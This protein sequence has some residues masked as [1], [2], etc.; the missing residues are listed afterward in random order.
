KQMGLTH[1]GKM[2]EANKLTTKEMQEQWKA[3]PAKDRTMMSGMMKEMSQT[4]DQ[5]SADIKSSG[6]L[7]VDDQTATLTVKKTTKDKNGTSTSTTTQNFKLDGG[8]CL[9]TR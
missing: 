8:Q 1:A 3:M 9:V 5:F 2:E 6:V 4:E 7:A